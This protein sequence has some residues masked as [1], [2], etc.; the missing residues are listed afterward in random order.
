MSDIALF[1][2]IPA[3]KIEILYDEQ[4]QPWF[5]RAALGRYLGLQH[6]HTSVPEI[7]MKARGEIM[8]GALCLGRSKNRHDMFLSLTGVKKV[9]IGSR[10]PKAIELA[11]WLG[12]DILST[13]ILSKEA[14]TLSCILKTFRGEDMKEQY[15]VD[16]YR[17]DL[18]FPTHKLAIECDEFGHKDRD[19][20]YEVTR[21]NHIET[22]L[23]CT[24]IRYNP[25]AKDF[26][27][28]DVLNSIINHIF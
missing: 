18:Y 1:N 20:T 14:E 6:I 13:K 10:K 15:T 28:F 2:A 9:I 5:K 4:D 7:D 24:F 19:I 11:K 26:D 25:D 17:I 27:I 3:G 23:G 8:G 21:Q 16:G 12:I 22:K